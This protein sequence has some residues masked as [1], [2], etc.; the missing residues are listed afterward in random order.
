MYN[1]S[2]KKSTEDVYQMTRTSLRWS[3]K[4]AVTQRDKECGQKKPRN[5]NAEYIEFAY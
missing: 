1:Y 2:A 5:K 4:L 3:E